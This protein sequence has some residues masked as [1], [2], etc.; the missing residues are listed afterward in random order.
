MTVAA[1]LRRGLCPVCGPAGSNRCHRP[2]LDRFER[3]THRVGRPTGPHGLRRCAATVAL[4]AGVDR[5]VMQDMSGHASIGAD[6]D[7][8]TLVLPEAAHEAAEAATRL[9]SRLGMSGLA[10]A[11]R[12]DTVT[13]E[14]R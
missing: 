1:D 9:V 8:Y 10:G 4:A 2:A 13:A 6:T 12:I 11:L 5:G 14:N 3:L 7:T